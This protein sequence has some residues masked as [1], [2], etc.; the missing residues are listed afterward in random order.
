MTRY[1]IRCGSIN[2][3]NSNLCEKCGMPLYGESKE[4]IIFENKIFTDNKKI[5]DGSEITK[6]IDY[7]ELQ[8]GNNLLNRGIIEEKECQNDFMVILNNKED[9]IP[10]E[11]KILN[12]FDNS[13]MIKCKKIKYNGR[14]ALYYKVGNLKS[15]EKIL[16][17]L[18]PI[19]FLNI[20]KNI[21]EE[22]YV[23]KNNGFLSMTGLDARIK[24]IYVSIS[25]NSVYLTYLPIKERIYM[26]ETFLEESLRR[27]LIYI[28]ENTPNIRDINIEEIL[29]VLK[30]PECSMTNVLQT[31]RQ[32]LSILL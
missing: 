5:N 28:I 14:Q 15:L 8:N 18:K 27:D 10:I 20:T 13:K 16:V 24:K 6:N 9:L 11:Y 26:D 23:I 31:I 29:Y 2:T 17:T 3:N 19:N 1:C 12:Q 30:E 22:I 32:K 7:S 4:K 25:D 21:L